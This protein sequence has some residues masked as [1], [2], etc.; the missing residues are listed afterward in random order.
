MATEQSAVRY[1]LYYYENSLMLSVYLRIMCYVNWRNGFGL[2]MALQQCHLIS[3]EAT[4]MVLGKYT[5]SV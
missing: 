5:I 1:T 4:Y 2:A 3:S